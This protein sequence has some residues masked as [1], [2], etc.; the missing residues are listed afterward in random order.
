MTID[1]TTKSAHKN[2]YFK[3]LK[4]ILKNKLSSKHTFEATNLYAIPALLYGFPVLDW[5]ITELIKIDREIPKMLQQYYAMHSQSDVTRL[6]LPRSN[7]QVTWGEKPV[8]QKTQRHCDEIGHDI[9]QLAAMRK[10]PGKINIKS[11]RINKLEVELK[12]KNM[13]RQF[14]R[15]LD[16]LYV[17]KERSNQWLKSSTLKRSAE[18]KIAVIQKQAISTIYIEKHVFNVEDDDTCRICRAGKETNHHII[19]GC[20]DLS[21]TKYLERHDNICQCIHVLLLLDHGFIEKYIPCYQHQPT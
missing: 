13:H 12:R 9:Q 21:P 16:Q 7:W 1:K 19:S 4:V 10:L 15:H 18:L 17:D 6:Y 8:H 11:A 20:H 2:E 5:T 3:Q 14:A